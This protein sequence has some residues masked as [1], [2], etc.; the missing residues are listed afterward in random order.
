[1]KDMSIIRLLKGSRRPVGLEFW[2][3]WWGK[4]FSF[5]KILVIKYFNLLNSFD[6]SPRQIRNFW[7]SF[8]EQKQMKWAS[9]VG[10]LHYDHNFFKIT[11]SLN[12]PDL[13]IEGDWAFLTF[14]I[15]LFEKICC[16]YSYVFHIFSF[17]HQTKSSYIL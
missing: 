9:L 12:I 6:T 1:M 13:T 3:R 14:Y 16:I 5:S 2:R 17:R 15:K 10:V 7:V 11:F 8:K 4:Q